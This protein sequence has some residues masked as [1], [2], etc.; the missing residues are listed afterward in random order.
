M[1]VL[2]KNLLLLFVA[3]CMVVGYI[4]PVIA[5][6]SWSFELDD[7]MIKTGYTTV[8]NDTK[9]SEVPSAKIGL[10]IH[11][12]SLGSD[13][14]ISLLN[15]YQKVIDEV[16]STG[17]INSKDQHIELEIPSL[18]KAGEYYVQVNIDNETREHKIMLLENVNLQSQ[19]SS[20]IVGSAGPLSNLCDELKWSVYTPKANQPTYDH[21]TEFIFNYGNDEIN[22]SMIDLYS[23]FGPEQG[24]KEGEFYYWN[25]H[26]NQWELIEIDGKTRHTFQWENG[27]LSQLSF[28][29]DK[30]YQTNQLKLKALDSNV[31]WENTLNLVEVQVWGYSPQ[32]EWT[33][34]VENPFV[35]V[36]DVEVYKDTKP[37]T[38]P[39]TKMNLFINNADTQLEYEVS[40]LDSHK[41]VIQNIGSTGIIRSAHEEIELTLPSSLEGGEYYI[42][43]DIDGNIKT[44]KIVILNNINLNSS[45]SANIVGYSGMLS[46]LIDKLQW[47]IYT[48]ISNRPTEDNPAD[49]VFDYKD[50]IMQV[51]SLDLYSCYGQ[52]QGPKVVEFYYWNSLLNQW[53]EILINGKHKQNLTWKGEELEKIEFQFDKAC[54]TSKIKMSVTDSYT[55]WENTNDIVEVQAWG[56]KKT[57]IPS[58]ELEQTSG[59]YGQENI[60]SILVK[61]GNAQ[62]DISFEL[63]DAKTHEP[64]KQP[65]KYTKKFETDDI[66]YS[67]V[68]PKSVQ[69]GEY[70]IQVKSNTF[71]LLSENYTIT[72]DQKVNYENCKEYINISVLDQKEY[73]NTQYMVDGNYK[74][75]WAISGKDNVSLILEVKPE[76]NIYAHIVLDKVKVYADK[77]NI[78]SVTLKCINQSNY[79]KNVNID[80]NGR[81]SNLVENLK[82]DWRNDS[83]GDYFL[84]EPNHLTMANIFVLDIKTKD[85]Q[86]DLSIHEIDIEGLHLSENILSE[87]KVSLNGKNIDSSDMVDFDIQ[88]FYKTKKGENDEYVFDFSP[89]TITTNELL[90]TAHYPK[91]QGISKVKIEIFKDNQWKEL[92]IYSMNYKTDSEIRESYQLLFD[93]ITTEKIKL[94]VLSANTVWDD[95]YL[96]TDINMIGKINENAQYIVDSL[97]KNIVIDQGV[98]KF[99]FPIVKEGY[100]LSI[101][102]SDNEDVIGLDGKIT[103]PKKDTYVHIQL[104]A[105]SKDGDIGISDTIKVF[106]PRGVLNGNHLISTEYDETTVYN[107]PA[108]GWVQYYEFQDTDVNKY[109]KEMDKLYKEGLKTNILYI[110]NPWSWY[111]PEEG[112]YA[113]EDPNS[114]LSQLIAGARKRKIQLAFRVLLDS[115]DC[116]QQC[117]PEYVFEA[118]AQWYE[119]DHTDHTTPLIDAK[120]PY[121]ND[122]IFL[123]KLDT[124]VKAFATEFNDDQ[125]IAFVDG[126]GFGNWG[127]THHVKYLA[128]YDDNVY[129]AVEKIVKIYNTHFSDVLLGAQEGQPENYGNETFD[130]YK[131]TDYPYTGAFDKKYD[132]IVRRDTFGWMNDSIRNQVIEWFHK[133]IPVYAENCYHSFEIREYWYNNAGYPTLDGILKQVVSDALT[134]RAN[135]LDAR[136]VMDCQSWLKNDQENGSNL[137]NQFALNGGYRLAPTTIELPQSVKV[138][139]NVNITSAW[140]N[141]GVGILP[142]KNKHWNQKY[143]VAFALLDEKTNEVVYQ[144]NAASNQIDP[145]D[146]LLENGNYRYDTTFTIPSSMKTGKYKLALAIVNEK[147]D[148]L[149]EINL[150][151][152][153][154][155]LTSDGWY[156]IDTLDV[157]K[158]NHSQ[159]NDTLD[160]PEESQPINKDPVIDSQVFG[161]EVNSKHKKNQTVQTGDEEEIVSYTILLICSMGIYMIIRKRKYS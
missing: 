99:P 151:I 85:K 79:Y 116:F 61:N 6:S 144:Y 86:S 158:D 22:I 153:N 135:T 106:V 134:C 82:V 31:V 92:G 17:I 52:G 96:F 63:V 58:V 7:D 84:I 44:E 28:Q 67:F 56:Y 146:W 71:N 132:F 2:K 154:A 97:D 142:N 41:N 27:E 128:K 91:S 109:W 29:F 70:K 68:I 36:G 139:E 114:H 131:D 140:R 159:G 115:T 3:F 9:P 129:D 117:T 123:E 37:A 59:V 33:L 25:S 111:E 143:K 77:D 38:S 136:I 161:D 90:Y 1:G 133:G 46:D 120:D 60:V 5:E 39:D 65:I 141:Y 78:D 138:G 8:Y 62:E 43:V 119:S 122:P 108:M 26:N 81:V 35:K 53:N 15:C 34:R 145:G 157:V 105:T 102:S 112:K 88:T 107:N 12:S 64:L 73:Q 19:I 72:Y 127:E 11:D 49:I 23:C 66:Q 55:E 155:D 16:K 121:I 40:L 76:N 80:E 104:K 20:T 87:A 89:R 13:Y 54:E 156:I 160:K 75:T 69:I 93:Q 74:N 126:M 24:I 98:T 100:K 50:S 149:P 30:E 57:D 152:K 18:L 51:Q 103:P 150:A 47:A 118:G 48:P 124:F 94:T 14:N 21:P 110:R 137:L 83:H 42:Q 4:T 45:I 101:Y 95:S 130:G 147:N 125:D 10:T 148:Y 32:K 113:W